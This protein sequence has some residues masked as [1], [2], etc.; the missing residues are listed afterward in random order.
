[1]NKKIEVAKSGQVSIEQIEE[2]K[3]I[4][5]QVYELGTATKV[6]YLKKPG[7]NELSFASA[8]GGDDAYKWNEALLNVCWLGGDEEIKTDDEQFLAVSRQFVEL[9]RV[10]DSYIKKL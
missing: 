5:G 2:W 10:Q 6:C 3:K 8:T 9:T 7:R 1:M 4:H